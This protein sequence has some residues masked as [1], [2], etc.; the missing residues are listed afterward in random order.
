MAVPPV[1]DAEPQQ[2]A[3]RAVKAFTFEAFEQLP[4][5]KSMFWGGVK[6]APEGQKQHR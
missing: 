1:G 4:P 3:S 6:E 2:D 5:G